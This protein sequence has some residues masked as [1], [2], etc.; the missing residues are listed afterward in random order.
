MLANTL[1]PGDIRRRIK[2]GWVEEG[3]LR[4]SS[5]YF[6][7]ARLEVDSRVQVCMK[8]EPASSS[9]QKVCP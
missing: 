2:Q 1:V 7:L 9:T 8:M 5:T 3:S 6:V 4:V